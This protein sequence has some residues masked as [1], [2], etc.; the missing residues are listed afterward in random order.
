[1]THPCC[2]EQMAST[3]RSIHLQ[4]EHARAPTDQFKP[5]EA[6]QVP[7]GAAALVHSQSSPTPMARDTRSLL[8]LDIGS[9]VAADAGGGGNRVLPALP[10]ALPN[11]AGAGRRA[12]LS[13][14]GRVERPGILPARSEPA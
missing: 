12:N 14:A 6:A 11:R 4:S 7:C 10:R 2:T 5:P 9:N 1:M 3:T 8:H 13:G